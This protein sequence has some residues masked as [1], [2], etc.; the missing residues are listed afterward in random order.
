MD[1]LLLNALKTF[2]RFVKFLL[3]N[4]HEM[5]WKTGHLVDLG[6]LMPWTCLIGTLLADITCMNGEA[7]V[8]FQSSTDPDH[9]LTDALSN[10]FVHLQENRVE[11]YEAMQGPEQSIWWDLWFLNEMRILMQQVRYVEMNPNRISIGDAIEA[12]VSF[13]IVCP[14]RVES[15]KWL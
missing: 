15:T 9:I 2:M 5:Q 12:Q 11:Y 7:P 14:S 6:N 8:P 13:S 3:M 1:I 4:S 10:D